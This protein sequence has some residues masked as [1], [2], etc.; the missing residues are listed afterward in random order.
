MSPGCGY[1]F[2]FPFQILN[3]LFSQSAFLIS[4]RSLPRLQIFKN[5]PTCARVCSDS[6]HLSVDYETKVNPPADTWKPYRL[7]P[8]MPRAGQWAVPSKEMG[9]NA[10]QM[11]QSLCDFLHGA[12]SAQHVLSSLL[13]L[14]DPSILCVSLITP[15]HESLCQFSEAK[16]CFLSYVITVLFSLKVYQMVLHLIAFLLLI[17]IR[18]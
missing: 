11:F 5:R 16:L 15:L 10:L 14:A 18:L 12:P 2:S 8:L 9:C 6:P 7:V 1:S 17:F 3:A 13:C 4:S